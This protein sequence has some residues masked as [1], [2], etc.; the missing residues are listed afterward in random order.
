MPVRRKVRLDELVALQGSRLVFGFRPLVAREASTV[1][2]E[3]EVP[4]GIR[5]RSEFRVVVGRVSLREEA[6]RSLGSML[7]CEA[8]IFVEAQIA[9]SS[10]AADSN[11]TFE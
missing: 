8:S 5:H 1:L 4:S 6:A 3:T 9:V 10:G 2:V 11:A 7:D